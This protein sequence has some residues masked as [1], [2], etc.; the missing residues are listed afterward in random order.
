MWMHTARR[1]AL[2]VSVLAALTGRRLTVTALGRS[3]VRQTKAK[4]C[5]KR[6]DHLLS[7]RHL[8][9]DRVQVYMA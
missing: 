3:I 4:H 7:N 9:A 5:I 1:H 6:A 2:A 8:H